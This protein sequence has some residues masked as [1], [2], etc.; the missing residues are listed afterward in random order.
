MSLKDAGLVMVQFTMQPVAIEEF[1]PDWVKEFFESYESSSD[2]LKRNVRNQKGSGTCVCYSTGSNVFNECGSVLGH[3][4]SAG[5]SLVGFFCQ[6]RL[7]DK[8]ENG[9][10]Q[11]GI[12]RFTFARD[13]R[14]EQNPLFM[15]YKDRIKETLLDLIDKFF[16]NVR[17]FDN[18]PPEG[19]DTR[20][21]SINLSARQIKDQK[22]WVK[23]ANR[24]RVGDAPVPLQ[25]SHVLVAEDDSFVIIDAPQEE[26]AVA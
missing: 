8:D 12:V 26:S 24:R 3:L 21:I 10:K 7:D 17:V 23:D 22:R 9:S 20:S 25:A 1:L 4:D 14:E 13:V 11:Y 19:L 18:P 2:W 16:W 6:M 5:F 15:E